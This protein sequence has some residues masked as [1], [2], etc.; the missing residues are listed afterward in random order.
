MLERRNSARLPLPLKIRETNGDYFYT[1]DAADLS[2][3]GV[4]VKNKVCFSAQESHSKLSFLLPD[5]SH[6]AN[7][8]ARVVRE[9]RR[10]PK[11]GCAIEF[12]NLTEEQRIALKRFVMA[13]AAS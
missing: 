9:N 8:T 4:F 5:G 3:E 10:G 6:L 1:W 13:R 7:I 11:Q 12:L 2:E